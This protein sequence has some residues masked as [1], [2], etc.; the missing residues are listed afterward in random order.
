MEPYLQVVPVCSSYQ[1][2]CGLNYRYVMENG[3]PIELFQAGSKICT[4][5]DNVTCNTDWDTM[6]N[7]IVE[8]LLTQSNT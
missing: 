7:A 3:E 6:D 1:S 5:A 8:R 4:C 2:L